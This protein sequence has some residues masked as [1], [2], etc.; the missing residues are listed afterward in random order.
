[1]KVI[2]GFT[3]P[4]PSAVKSAVRSVEAARD[5]DLHVPDLHGSTD[6]AKTI[7]RRAGKRAAK[8][9]TAAAARAS[10][11]TTK[12]ASKRLL[13]VVLVAVIAGGAVGIAVWVVQRKRA[14]TAPSNPA[15]VVVPEGGVV[16]LRFAV[17]CR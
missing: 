10:G 14:V 5:L 11:R 17:A 13:R 3:A 4:P 7:A 12:R 1:L 8:Q 15:T 6:A 16:E 9:A 2:F